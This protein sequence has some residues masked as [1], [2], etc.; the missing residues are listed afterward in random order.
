MGIGRHYRSESF[1]FLIKS[2][3]PLTIPLVVDKART[4]LQTALLCSAVLSHADL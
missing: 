4:C 3:S 2:H 1:L